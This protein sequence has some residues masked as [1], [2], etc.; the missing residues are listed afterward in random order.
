MKFEGTADI[1]GH[2][3]ATQG[4]ITQHSLLN[5]IFSTK[6]PI[7]QDGG[8][9]GLQIKYSCLHAV[10]LYLASRLGWLTLLKVVYR[11]NLVLKQNYF[12]VV[13]LHVSW[14]KPS[15]YLNYLADV[16]IKYLHYIYDG[17]K[18]DAFF[19]ELQQFSWYYLRP[20]TLR[21]WL[22]ESKSHFLGYN[23]TYK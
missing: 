15:K 13:K 3:S 17:N 7:Q 12:F 19:L 21:D 8:W 11:V 1:D 2:R 22:A 6:G 9:S 10:Y 23:L 5:S 18:S 4:H 20:M 16:M 14:W